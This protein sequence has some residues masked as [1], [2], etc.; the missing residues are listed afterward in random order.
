ML[1][2]GALMFKAR[3]FATQVFKAYGVHMFTVLLNGHDCH[4]V[5]GFFPLV[6]GMHP[7]A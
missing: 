1:T 6:T 7:R 5:L 2:S 3:T 4:R